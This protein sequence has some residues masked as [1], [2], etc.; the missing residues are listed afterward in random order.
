MFY[1][2]DNSAI[3]MKIIEFRVIETPG[4]YRYV[5]VSTMLHDENSD[6]M[7]C[8]YKVCRYWKRV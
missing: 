4:I 6:N 3:S 7:F 5:F 1:K 8:A 2:V